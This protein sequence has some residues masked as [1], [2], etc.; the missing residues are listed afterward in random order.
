MKKRWWI[1]ASL[2]V[3]VVLAAALAI[4]NK[5]PVPAIQLMAQD[6]TAT[7]TVTGE[8]KGDIS[9]ALS[10]PV[11][12]KIT[13]ILVDEG[14]TIYPGEELVQLETAPVR[15]QLSQAQSQAAQAQASYVHTLQGTRPEEISLWE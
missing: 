7:L 2:A 4:S 14:D 1:L 9:V 13:N 11:S 15:S 12:A 8:V 6:V 10:P 5:E 3:L